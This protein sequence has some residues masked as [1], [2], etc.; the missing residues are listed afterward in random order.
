MTTAAEDRERIAKLLVMWPRPR[1]GQR[2][3]L[4]NGKVAE[5][6]TLRK[7]RDV[8]KGMTELDATLMGPKQ[9]ALYGKYWLEIYYEA[10]IMGPGAMGIAVV[11]PSQVESILP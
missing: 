4:H 8:L 10:E 11:T 9:Q 1:V 7:A 2:V 6:L 3:K 5:V